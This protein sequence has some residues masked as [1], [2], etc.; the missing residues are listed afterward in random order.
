MKIYY[1]RVL[2]LKIQKF[3]VT[4]DLV[5]DLS[6]SDLFTYSIN[7]KKKDGRYAQFSLSGIDKSRKVGY[8]QGKASLN[9]LTDAVLLQKIKE[10]Y[11]DYDFSKLDY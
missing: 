4:A 2:R 10:E 6:N 5:Q 1:G 9:N 8:D 3:Q 7:I 11:P